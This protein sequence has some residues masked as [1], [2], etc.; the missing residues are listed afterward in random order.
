MEK[1]LFETSFDA[2]DRK[3]AEPAAAP[4]PTY[5]QQ[6]LEAV[7]QAGFAEGQAAGEAQAQQSLAAATER[8]VGQIDDA[9][10]E[11]REQLVFIADKVRRESLAVAMSSLRTLFPRLASAHGL[12]EVETMIADCLDLARSEPAIV[13]KFNPDVLEAA[14]APLETMA[15]AR[16]FAGKL[17]ILADAKLPLDGCA[18]EWAD[19]GAERNSEAVLQQIEQ[20][21]AQ[22]MD[23]DQQSAPV[24]TDATSELA[25]ES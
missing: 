24:S 19:G 20:L 3:R 13:F 25:Q 11:L 5:S 23:D 16:A 22:A 15:A 12:S 10:S 18:V 17:V 9:L 2:K 14:R 21:V 4:A 6:E 8:A 1:F 7:R